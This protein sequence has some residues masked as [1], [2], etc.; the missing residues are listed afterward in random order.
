MKLKI[1]YDY[2]AFLLILTIFFGLG[3]LPGSAF[4]APEPKGKTHSTQKDLAID[5][6]L[7]L[8]GL[9]SKVANTESFYVNINQLD[10]TD[11]PFGQTL[12]IRSIVDQVYRAS[13]FRENVVEQVQRKYN[14]RHVREV[15][16]WYRT[17]VATNILQIEQNSF[18]SY[19]HFRV[20]RFIKF[21]GDDEEKKR[22]LKILQVMTKASGQA[23]YEIGIIKVFAGM[24]FPFEEDYKGKPVTTWIAGLSD[25][26][27]ISM[28][29]Q[30]VE[31]G[32]YT[33]RDLSTDEL[34]Q[35]KNFLISDA[36][37][38][39]HKTIHWGSENAMT[40]VGAT[41]KAFQ[42]RIYAEVEKK[43]ADHMLLKQ[44]APPGY[45]YRLIRKRDPFKPLIIDG[46]LQ[47][48]RVKPKKKVKSQTR[49]RSTKKGK[50]RDVRGYGRE[51]NKSPRIPLEVFKRLKNDDPDLY[52]DLQYFATLFQNKSKLKSMS[53][54]EY[55][56]VVSKYKAVLTRAS[57][58]KLYPTPLQIG[59]KSI[60]LMGVIWKN[61]EMVALVE[62]KG[63]TGQTV[64]K[65]VLIGPNYGVVE[66]IKRDEIIIV[67]RSR[68]YLGNIL[69]NKKSIEFFNK[70]E[71]G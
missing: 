64:K 47:V 28:Q 70:P 32:F 69:T 56:G 63:S 42:R 40:L 5:E 65:G 19:N 50:A 55:R 59:Y 10:K 43:G 16:K 22:R 6:M 61:Q 68:D 48:A 51:F 35:Y 25:K 39:F 53:R 14:A 30:I 49:S 34:L 12:F 46:V 9:D 21:Y 44:I 8:S 2:S 58:K 38:W 17:P 52:A 45:R 1:K 36:G 29:K 71:E 4:S 54:T 33:Y 66:S 26:L 24:L 60:K 31:N 23:E 41:A 13:D 57:E 15:I 20:S 62:L 3:V 18:R 7:R 27:K 67:E 11:L 37:R